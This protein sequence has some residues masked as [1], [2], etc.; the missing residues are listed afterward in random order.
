MI[1]KLLLGIV[2]LYLLGVFGASA[3]YLS[4]YWSDEWTL[5]ELLSEA[6]QVG[7]VWPI[8]V[9]EKMAGH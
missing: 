2:V 1:K 9:V 6:V 4:L 3:G 8:S 5:S 7:V